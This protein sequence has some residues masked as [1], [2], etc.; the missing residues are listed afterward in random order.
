[1]EVGGEQNNNNNKSKVRW[2]PD[3]M[4]TRQK[5]CQ[6]PGISPALPGTLPQ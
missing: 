5:R 3:Y 4:A 1:M 6:G 2:L